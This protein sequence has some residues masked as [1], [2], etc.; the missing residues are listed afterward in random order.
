MYL[1]DWWTRKYKYKLTD[2]HESLMIS[3]IDLTIAILIIL[4]LKIN[5]LF[6]VEYLLLNR[7]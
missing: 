3:L 5:E 6:N 2:L 7:L 1:W 4:F